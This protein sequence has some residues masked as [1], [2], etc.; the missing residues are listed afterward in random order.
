MR[1]A[2]D[3]I[4]HKLLA[5]RRLDQEDAVSVVRRKA[6]A[7]DWDYLERWAGE[8]AAV[9]RREDMPVSLTRLRD[10]S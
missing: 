6:D 5:G 1:T 9:P 10:E 8:F 4:I 3:L 2:E 7:I